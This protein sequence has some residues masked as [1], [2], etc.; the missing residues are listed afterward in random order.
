MPLERKT[1]NPA[2]PISSSMGVT[3]RRAGLPKL[4]RIVADSGRARVRVELVAVAT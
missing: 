4:P 2:C 1:V 3:A